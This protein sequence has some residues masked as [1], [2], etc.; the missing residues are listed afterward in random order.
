MASVR[1]VRRRQIVNCLAAKDVDSHRTRLPV[2]RRVSQSCASSPSQ[3][4]FAVFLAVAAGWRRS[5]DRTCLHANS[6]LTGNFTGK[7][8]ILAVEE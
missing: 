4:D 3:V 8:A 6:L 5:A 7:L 1:G 2:Q